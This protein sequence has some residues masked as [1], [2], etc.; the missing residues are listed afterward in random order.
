VALIVCTWLWGRR[1]T[2][3]DV[4][5]LHGGVHRNLKQPHRFVCITDHVDGYPEVLVHPEYGPAELYEIKISDRHLTK[6]DGCFARLRMFDPAW[7]AE[8]GL[9]D[10]LVCLDLDTVITGA[11]DM[12]F[13]RPE[14]FCILQ[15]ANASNPCPFNGSIMM[16]RPGVHSKVWRDFSLEAA[17]AVPFYRY[18]ED[19]AW[20]AAKLPHAAGWRAGR[21]GVYAFKKPGWPA[22]ESLPTDARIVVFPGSRKPVQFAHLNWIRENWR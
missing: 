4:S 7:Q 9:T 20:I 22:G 1:Y 14:P 8:L 10:R 15:G 17:A 5:R 2:P 19:Q 21:D 3:D 13:D 6:I 18:P 16:L 12:L 11:L